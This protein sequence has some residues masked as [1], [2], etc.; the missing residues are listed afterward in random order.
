MKYK[1][2]A[3]ALIL[4]GCQTAN[5]DVDDS[6]FVGT[7]ESDWGGAIDTT[8]I[9]ENV[10]QGEAS[11]VYA[12]DNDTGLTGEQAAVAEV[13]GGVL[14][15]SGEGTQFDLRMNDDGT[16]SATRRY[17]GGVNNGTFTPV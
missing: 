11:I 6:A 5:P 15:W 14:S 3:A 4:T 7:C 12:W 8:L 16:I 17:S 1:A 10:N 9:V 13:E 2:L